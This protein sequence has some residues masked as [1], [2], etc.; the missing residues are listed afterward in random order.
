MARRREVYDPAPA[1]AEQV[2]NQANPPDRSRPD[3]TDREYG[4]LG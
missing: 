3:F 1:D 2:H 4:R